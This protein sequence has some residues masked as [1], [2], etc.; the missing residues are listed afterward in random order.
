MSD[1][2]R[3]EILG[4]AATVIAERGLCD[5][6]IA[7]VA[8]VVGVSPALVLY[9]FPNKVALL[10]EALVHLERLFHERVARRLKDASTAEEKLNIMIDESCPGP[11]AAGGFPDSWLLWPATWEMSRLDPGLAAARA[12]LD[13]AWRAQIVAI[14]EDGMSSG[15]FSSINAKDFSMQFAAMLEG[16]AI[17]AILGDPMIDAEKMGQLARSF[18]GSVLTPPG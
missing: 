2:R 12:R 4:A 5:T 11:A 14:V 8:E 17:E 6:R 1:S 10:T 9:Y 18:A 15:E 16:L 7:D 13:E 3:V